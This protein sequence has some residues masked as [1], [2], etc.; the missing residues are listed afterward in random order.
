MDRL[1]LKKYHKSPFKEH[2]EFLEFYINDKPLS[3]QIDALYYSN[4]KSI[5]D[6]WTGV[7]GTN[8]HHAEIVKVK[9]LLSKPV[10]DK[11]IRAIYAKLS[12]ADFP[13]YLERTREELAN[14]EII[15]YCCAE[16]GDYDCGGVAI[17]IDKTDQSVIWTVLESEKQPLRF[18][19]EKY[20]Y[21]DVL[22]VYLNQLL[23]R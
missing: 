1:T 15:V 16:C 8:K 14:P 18:E 3:E 12:D 2:K 9:Q 20:S 22:G 6:N 19:F 17:T 5:L 4:K 11:E 23:K 21:Y 7:L 10:S 13:Y